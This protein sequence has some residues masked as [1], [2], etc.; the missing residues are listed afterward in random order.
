MTTSGQVCRLESKDRVNVRRKMLLA[1]VLAAVVSVTASARAEEI[2]SGAVVEKIAKSSQ[3]EKAGIQEG[4][5]LLRRVRGDAKGEIES[6]FD[7][8][9][10]ETE[11]VNERGEV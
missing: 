4:D 9:Q 5:L 10:V 8:S 6:P 1:I 3:A 2:Q 7:L 11:Q